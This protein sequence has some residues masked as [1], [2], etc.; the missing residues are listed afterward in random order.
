MRRIYILRDAYR[1]RNRIVFF[2]G[3]FIF[4]EKP[5]KSNIISLNKSEKMIANKNYISQFKFDFKR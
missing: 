1:A 2:N 5:Y 4:K 3:G